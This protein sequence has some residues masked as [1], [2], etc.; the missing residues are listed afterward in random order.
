MSA[1]D[2]ITA[3]KKEFQARLAVAQANEKCAWDNVGILERARQAQD[4]E[5]DRLREVIRNH[6]QTKEKQN[7]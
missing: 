5:I 7:G 1:E 4:K 3:L 2:D 6:G